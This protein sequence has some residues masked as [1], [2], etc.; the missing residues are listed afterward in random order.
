M[1]DVGVLEIFC[2]LI[3]AL[4]FQFA[5]CLYSALCKGQ[6]K[7]ELT[8]QWYYP[9]MILA[10]ILFHRRSRPSPHTTKPR[11]GGYHGPPAATLL[12]RSQLLKGTG[13]P[14]FSSARSYVSSLTTATK[15]II[16][17]TVYLDTISVS[18]NFSSFQSY[19][20]FC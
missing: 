14:Y 8:V 6:H 18:L 12:A 17:K 20:G 13:G 19:R 16:K 3:L 15:H 7:H 1:L 2:V 5:I 11:P 10:G 9:S 4:H